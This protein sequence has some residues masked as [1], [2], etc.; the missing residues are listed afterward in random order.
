MNTLIVRWQRPTSVN[1]LDALLTEKAVREQ[2]TLWGFEH[3]NLTEPGAREVFNKKMQ[4]LNEMNS[5]FVDGEQ[6]EMQIGIAR[7]GLSHEDRTGS[8]P[9]WLRDILSKRMDYDP[10]NQ[11]FFCKTP[12]S[13]KLENL[14]TWA[15]EVRVFPFYYFLRSHPFYTLRN[16]F[17]LFALK[18]A[19]HNDA[20]HME[21]LGLDQPA[22]GEDGYYEFRDNAF[23]D[24]M[25]EAK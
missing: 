12:D 14:R 1:P 25:T 24:S 22:P 15:N 4:Q 21:V 23:R 18:R 10:I 3:K 6:A 19:L 11:Q 8:W 7:V 17:S 20:D 16:V 2:L 5:Q 13:V 9:Q